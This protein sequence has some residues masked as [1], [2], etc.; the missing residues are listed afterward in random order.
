MANQQRRNAYLVA[1]TACVLAAAFA[2]RGLEA[3]IQPAADDF[4]DQAG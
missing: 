1:A 4:V 2:G 3:Q